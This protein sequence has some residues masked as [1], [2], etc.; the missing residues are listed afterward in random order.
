MLDLDAHDEVRSQTDDESAERGTAEP[1]RASRT[2]LER[3]ASLAAR[4]VSRR[5]GLS[6]TRAVLIAQLAGLGTR[7]ER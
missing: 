6:P 1:P 5:Y 2:V 4:I 7:E 3:S